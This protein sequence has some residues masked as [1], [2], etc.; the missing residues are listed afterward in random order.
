MRGFADRLGPA[1]LTGDLDPESQQELFSRLGR[2]VPCC[3]HSSPV[4]SAQAGSGCLV[5]LSSGGG[6]QPL[7]LRQAPG[8]GGHP[9]RVL[10]CLWPWQGRGWPS[11]RWGTMVPSDDHFLAPAFIQ[12]LVQELAVDAFFGP[13]L[14]GVAATTL[15]KPVDRHGT[16]ILCALAGP[17]WRRRGVCGVMLPAVPQGPGRSGPA[18]H[19][20]WRQAARAG[21]PGVP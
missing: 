18:V 13:V 11:R 16:A 8:G 6:R 1:A 19:T 10:V 14:R 7:R 21:T 17:A 15:G 4:G 20:R 12:S 3:R 9:R 2:D 5:R